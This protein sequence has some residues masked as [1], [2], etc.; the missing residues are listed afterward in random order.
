MTQNPILKIAVAAVA[1]F[2]FAI[3]A[4]GKPEDYFRNI[5]LSYSD[6]FSTEIEK[7]SVVRA[8]SGF[9]CFYSYEST[10]S[11]S[12]RGRFKEGQP[13]EFYSDVPL[14]V[15]TPYLVYYSL[16]DESG[17]RM[18]YGSDAD[19]DFCKQKMSGV[20]LKS[21]EVHELVDVT[22]ADKVEKFVKF[23]DPWA[24]V[25]GPEHDRQDSVHRYDYTYVRSVLAQPQKS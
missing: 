11:E 10:V 7:A 21:S 9:V 8:P 24:D 19:H 13:F 23:S 17:F 15:G 3:G 6:F 1:C 16:S 12:I 22:V 2:A 4:Q 18:S 5:L 20:L 14:K 25:L